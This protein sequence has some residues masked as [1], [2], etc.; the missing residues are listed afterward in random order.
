MLSTKSW[1]IGR[2]KTY[3]YAPSVLK[4]DNGETKIYTCGGGLQGDAI[5]LTVFNNNGVKTTD[6]KLVLSPVVSNQQSDDAAH[7]CSPSVIKRSNSTIQSMVGGALE[8]YLMYFECA[9]K[10]YRRSDGVE[11][12]T[13][14]QTCVAFSDDGINWKKYNEDIWASQGRFANANEPPTAVMKISSL[15]A[16]TYG[17]EKVSG[18]WWTTAM[19][20]EVGT[21]GVGHPSVLVKDEQIWLYYFNSMSEN[22]DQGMLLAKSDDGLHFY[23]PVKP[24]S[25]WAVAD[26]RYI[27]IPMLGHNGFFVSYFDKYYNYSWDGLTWQLDSNRT[28]NYLLGGQPSSG[29]CMAPGT[30]TF[31]SDKY[32]FIHSLDVDIYTNEGYK[33]NNVGDWCT[34][35][36]GCTCYSPL[37]DQSRGYTWQ[38]YRY[39]GK[40]TS[41]ATPSPSPTPTPISGDLTGD[42]HVN[43]FDYN[44][45]VSKFNNP[46]T[47]FDY[48]SLV[49]NFGK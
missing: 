32:G 33:G 23:P 48:N 21:Y 17:I 34:A 42:G 14:T 39:Q 44:L 36:N 2:A 9:P 11:I 22:G 43:I 6:S 15:M 20:W 13:F 7:T 18:K 16:Q 47:I 12:N 4:E 30:S 41:L 49:A 27:A 46:Y 28:D 31:G 24:T 29:K 8:K 38:V 37:E 10:V 19:Q 40:F 25:L 26:V 5:Y 45:L 1:E 3:D 35:T